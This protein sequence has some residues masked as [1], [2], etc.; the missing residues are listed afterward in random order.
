ML[1][2][3][4]LFDVVEESCIKNGVISD[5]EKTNGKIKGRMMITLI[6]IPEELGITIE[7]QENPPLAFGASFDF[8][9]CSLGIALYPKTMK[10]V[11][12]VWVTPQ[13]EDAEPP[14]KE[15][16]KFFIKTL[17]ES[18]DEDGSFGYPMYTFISD[19]GDFTCIPTLEK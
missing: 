8:Y 15:W 6:D 12:G 18:I 10:F 11:S 3:K 13:V 19:T 14:A 5:F 1:F 9:D 17:A 4:E 16:I 2:D 7:D